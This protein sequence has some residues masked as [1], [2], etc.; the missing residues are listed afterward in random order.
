[1]TQLSLLLIW[2]SFKEHNSIFLNIVTKKSYYLLIRN[3]CN[4]IFISRDD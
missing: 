1:M 2:G 4:E 3:T